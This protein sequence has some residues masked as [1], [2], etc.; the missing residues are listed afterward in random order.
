MASDWLNPQLGICLVF[1]D[2]K[3]TNGNEHKYNVSMHKSF[4]GIMGLEWQHPMGMCTCNIE[5]SISI[6]KVYK[7]TLK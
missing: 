1:L 7:Y 4:I 5:V 2:P 3:E 6:S